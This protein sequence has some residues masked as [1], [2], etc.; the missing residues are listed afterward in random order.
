MKNSLLVILMKFGQ[1]PCTI[2]HGHRPN[3]GA[4]CKNPI[5]IGINFNLIHN[6][7]ICIVS[8]KLL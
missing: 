7:R 3:F 2:A 4:T 1:K 6:I 8:E 5:L